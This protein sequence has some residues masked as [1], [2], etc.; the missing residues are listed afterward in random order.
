MKAVE[1]TEKI[2]NKV[3]LEYKEIEYMVNSYVKGRINDET[4][5]NFIWAIYNKGLSMDEIYYLTDV[6]IKSGE[7]IDLSSIN[8][9]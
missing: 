7:T 4:M 6:M 8:K 9:K 2:N 1:I 5:S 3:K